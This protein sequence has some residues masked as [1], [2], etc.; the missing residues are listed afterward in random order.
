MDNPP[1]WHPDPTGR[2][3][4]R[5]WD[6]ERWTEHVA[7]AGVSGLDPVEGPP[8]HPGVASGAGATERIPQRSWEQT[9]PGGSRSWPQ[10][11]SVSPGARSTT[12]GVALAAMI[13]GILSLLF[14]WFPVLGG[15]GGA[16]A[17]ILGFV[18]RS[19]VRSGTSAGAG[20]AL[21]GI[22]TGAIAVVINLLVV[23][24][25]VAFF[26]GGTF[27]G[28]ISEYSECVERTGDEDRCRRQMEDELLGRTDT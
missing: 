5:W 21:T 17:L 15:L 3:D 24:A 26:G 22:I 9:D 19:R 23:A 6:G 12:D 25:A 18:G 13:V 10:S 14:A 8:P 7:D 27:G 1:A 4:H 11:G 2:H 28:V 20:Q 16:I